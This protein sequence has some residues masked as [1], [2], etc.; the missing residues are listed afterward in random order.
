[1][2]SNDKGWPECNVIME[3][4]PYDDLEDKAL[5]RRFQAII[6]LLSFIALF[7]LLCLIIWGATRSFKAQISVKVDKLLYEFSI[8]RDVL[9][10]EQRCFF[11]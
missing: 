10:H 7:M 6:A 1:M 5:S 8:N 4:G 3:E 9:E 11:V 2:I